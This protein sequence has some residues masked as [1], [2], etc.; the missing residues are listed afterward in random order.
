MQRIFFSPRLP[1]MTMSRPGF[2]RQLYS[3]DAPMRPMIANS[4]PNPIVA[5]EASRISDGAR[6]RI[7]RSL[8]ACM[9]Q[10]VG[11]QSPNA[12]NHD[13]SKLSGHQHPP[14]A[15]IVIAK[16]APIGITESWVRARQA[17]TRPKAAAANE[18]A[19]AG[20]NKAIGL[21]PREMSKS[22]QP[23]AKRIVN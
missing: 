3:R 11:I 8:N 22:H 19:I 17:I 1:Q 12:R 9:V 20:R 2:Q 6:L 4:T 14:I 5:A 13:G 15:D 21:R 10:V 16:T 23:I 18:I 7:I